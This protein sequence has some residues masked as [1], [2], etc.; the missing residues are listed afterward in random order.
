MKYA[1]KQ[2]SIVLDVNEPSLLQVPTLSLHECYWDQYRIYN[3]A[4]DLFFLLD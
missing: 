1:R 2:S 4:C 3:V